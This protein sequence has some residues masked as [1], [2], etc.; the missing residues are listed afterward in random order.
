MDYFKNIDKNKRIALLPDHTFW[1]WFYHRW[2]YNGSGFLWYGIEQP[3]VSRTFDSWSS[4]S[5]GYFW[6]MKTAAEAEN[7]EQFEAVEGDEDRDVPTE[8]CRGRGQDERRGGPVERAP[9]GDDRHFDQHRHGHA[10][11]GHR[12][13]Y[14]DLQRG[15]RGAAAAAAL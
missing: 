7:V 1:G 14:G 3:I 4:K 12:G 15:Q 9:G 11:P 13:E 6:E 5:E 10:R 2:G 8:R